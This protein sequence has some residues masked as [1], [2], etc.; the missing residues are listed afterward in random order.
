MRPG[1]AVSEAARRA[2]AAVLRDPDNSK[3]AK[4]S[5]GEALTQRRRATQSVDLPAE[6]PAHPGYA[7][8]KTTRKERDD[9]TCIVLRIYECGCTLKH[10][11]MEPGAPIWGDNAR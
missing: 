7:E 2:A 11:L 9:R 5:R 6:C 3:T 10:T 4:V 8:A 1:N